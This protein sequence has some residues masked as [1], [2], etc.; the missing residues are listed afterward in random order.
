MFN[1]FLQGLADVHVE[2]SFANAYYPCDFAFTYE[3]GM[4]EGALGDK[5]KTRFYDVP[6]YI[7]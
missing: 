2:I 1:C 7:S 4:G 6:M 3:C 5:S